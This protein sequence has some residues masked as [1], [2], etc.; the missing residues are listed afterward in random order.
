MPI[1]Q[2]AK[3]TMDERLITLDWLICCLPI[4]FITIFDGDENC[5]YIYQCILQIIKFLAVFEFTVA[6][7]SKMWLMKI[8]SNYPQWQEKILPQC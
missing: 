2:V 8:R 5:Q 4:L 1:A 7:K 3:R 6:N